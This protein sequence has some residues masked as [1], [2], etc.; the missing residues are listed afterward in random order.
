MCYSDTGGIGRGAQL[1][2]RTVCSLIRVQVDITVQLHG[3]LLVGTKRGKK[4][5]GVSHRV[6]SSGGGGIIPRVQLRFGLC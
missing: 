4:E 1:A 6:A 3:L 5:G 2:G